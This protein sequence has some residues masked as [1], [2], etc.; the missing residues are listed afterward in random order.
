MT[1]PLL[2]PSRVCG[3]PYRKSERK[4]RASE[5]ENGGVGCFAGC[6]LGLW[7]GVTAHYTPKDFGE[8]RK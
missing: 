5:I 2:S 6:K 8:Y 7:F 1:T 4:N 3:N